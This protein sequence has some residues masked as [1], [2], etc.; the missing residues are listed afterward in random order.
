[1][2][3]RKQILIDE[4]ILKDCNEFIDESKGE[5]ADFTQM[6]RHSLVFYIIYKKKFKNF[7]S[8]ILNIYDNE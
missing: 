4:R 1:M 6:V 2:K 8:N 5:I 7:D 3:I